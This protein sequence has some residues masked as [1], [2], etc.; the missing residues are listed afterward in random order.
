MK[1]VRP[2]FDCWDKGTIDDARAGKRLV[3]FQEIV[4]HMVFEIKMDFT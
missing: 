2:A 3:G 1:N 4:C